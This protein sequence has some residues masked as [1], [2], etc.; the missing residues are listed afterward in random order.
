MKGIVLF[1]SVLFFC[2]FQ[3]CKAAHIV[4]G[5]MIYEYL[6]PGASSGSNQ[7]R[8][9]LK[10]FRDQQTTGAA[11]PSSVWIGIFN[12]DNNTQ[13]PGPGQKYDIQKSDEQAVIVNPFPS[14]ITNPPTL[15]YNVGIFTFTVDLPVN[16]N[17]YTASY[18]TCCRINNLENVFNSQ[19]VGGTGSTYSCVIPVIADQSPQYATSIDA[20]CRNKP[21]SLRFNATDKDGDSL[22]YSYAYAYN[23]GTAQNSGN[24]NP[25]PPPYGSVNYINSYSSNTPLGVATI[26]PNTG[27]I[28]GIAPDI[29]K[30]VVCVD[31]K[32]YRR[33]VLVG[34]HRKDFI[35]N[36][37]DCDF[38]GAQLDPKAVSCD[39]FD[40]SFVNN[41]NSPLNKSFFWTFGDPGSGSADTSTLQ[42]PTHVYSDTGV[43]VYKLIVNKGLQCS[44]SAT[45]IQKV[46][47]GFFPGIANIGRCINSDIQFKD[48]TRTNYGRV[49]SWRWDF[50]DPATTADTSLKAN[51]TYLYDKVGNYIVQ[52]TV[53]SDKGC[54]KTISDTLAIIDKPVFSITNDT[55]ICSIDDLQLN[56][57]GT[58]SIFW[59]PAYR[60][61][62][63]TSFAPVVNPKVT[64]TYTATLTETPGC[65]ASKSVVVNVVDN[66]T[67]R[68]AND[69]TICQTDSVRLNVVSDGL[70]YLWTPSS[71]IDV[72]TAKNPL[73]F[74]LNKTTFHVIASIGKCSTSGNI[75]IS[76]VPY[77]NARTNADTTLCFPAGLQLQASG[78]VSYVWSP[79]TFLN[80]SNIPNPIASPSQSIRYVVAV[81]DNLGCPKPAFDTVLVS[82]EDIVADAGPRDTII[83]VNQPLQLNGTGAEAFF[84]FPGIGLNNQNIPNPVAVLSDNQQYV[85]RVSS[86]AGCSSTDTINVIVYKVKPDLYVPNA[87]TP[88]GD[89]INDVFRPVPIG[90][91][92][93]NYFRVFDRRGKLIFSTSVL[94]KGWDGTYKGAPQDSEVF[95]WMA[96]GV[97]YQDNVIFKKGTATLIR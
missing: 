34:T 10:L 31:V 70:H 74:N 76:T 50:G 14:C 26:N 39:G 90:M 86:A 56:A 16:T 38:A 71:L 25:A 60:I 89:G 54:L 84:W 15:I 85:L 93:I 23:G 41:N 92:R 53:G 29:G 12:N 13:F 44:D 61:N 32:S 40:V 59:S 79:A 64:T 8:I 77:P 11:M 37:T 66:V 4:G 91:K 65:A 5:E 20:I 49:N 45:Q 62:N 42:S 46:Y 69:S 9:T 21:F 33:G 68:T 88:D 24:I 78:G 3:P 81:R 82:V 36:V 63:Q 94:N 95:V 6:G 30:Y 19:G 97:D 28:S 87:F 80:N 75:T 2:V 72:D 83:V 52:L 51:P 57:T 73:A 18:Q 67:L 48:I 47:P 7:Y 35:V 58:G 96:E 43:F 17:G 22:V 55:L 1:F 27:I